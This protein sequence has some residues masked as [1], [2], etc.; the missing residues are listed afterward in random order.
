[1]SPDDREDAKRA[2]ALERLKNNPQRREL[3]ERVQRAAQDRQVRSIR[4]RIHAALERAGICSDL[5]CTW[6]L[7]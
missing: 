7:W 1:M 6:W 5:T 2:A 4:T 3:A